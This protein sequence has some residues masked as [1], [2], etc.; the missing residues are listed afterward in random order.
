MKQCSNVF[1]YRNLHYRDK[2]VY[3]VR[4]ESTKRVSF[5]SSLVYL[6]DV[7][8]KVGKA[9]QSRVRKEKRKNVHAGVKGSLA[10]MGL[11]LW[12]G[13]F[14]QVRYNPYETGTFVRCDNGEPVH[15]AKKVLIN[16]QGVFCFGIEE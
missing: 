9:G 16:E 12:F 14:V 11:D 15:R 7:V 13:P 1:V 6:Y 3:S 4:N 8:F 5:H 10:P 2:V